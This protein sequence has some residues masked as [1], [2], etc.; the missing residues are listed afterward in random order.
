MKIAM[1]SEH[2][3]PL[4]AVGDVDA[5]GQNVHVGALATALAERGHQVDVF[6]RRDDPDAPNC[7]RLARGVLVRHLPAGPPEPIPKDELPPYLPEMT[8]ALEAALR[9][10]AYDVLHAHFWMS[11]QVSLDA[12]RSL[13]IPVLQTFH[14]LGVVKKRHQGAEDTSP[15]QRL[16]TEARIARDVDRIIATCTDEMRELLAITAGHP[17]IDVVPCGVDTA[18]FHPARLGPVPQRRCRYRVLS[19]GRMVRRKGIDDTIRA[20]AQIPDTELL[21][22]G[23]PSRQELCSDPE[24]ARLQELIA[25]LGV[26]DRVRLLGQVRRSEVPDLV[27]SSDVVACLPWYEPFGIVPLEAMACGVPVLGSAVGGLLD[28]VVDGVTGILIPA[29]SPDVAAERLGDLLADEAGRRTMGEAGV[30][31]VE[32][33]FRWDRVAAR[34]EASYLRALG[35]SWRPEKRRTELGYDGIGRADRQT[36]KVA[37]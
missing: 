13:D 34:T 26:P 36:E 15:P 12:A 4:A 31:R 1:L 37:G 33:R 28:T 10:G 30:R 11:G 18:Q 32:E 6:T 19:L 2:A 23:G 24:G 16:D 7:V 22:A 8:S 14:A 21:I 20:V 35:S 27:C 9:R 29:R 17:S 5:G 3:S 25:E